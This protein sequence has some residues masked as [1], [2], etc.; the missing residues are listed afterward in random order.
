MSPSEDLGKLTNH[1]DLLDESLIAVAFFSVIRACTVFQK[2]QDVGVSFD[3][4]SGKF[5]RRIRYDDRSLD[6]RVERMY[7][8]A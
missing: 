8:C 3:N 6:S 7:T 5:D 4:R 2:P 1:T